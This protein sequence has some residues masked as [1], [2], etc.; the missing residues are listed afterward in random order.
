MT[1]YI[2]PGVTLLIGQETL[3][4]GARVGTGGI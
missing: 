1:Y 3:R 4:R 2:A